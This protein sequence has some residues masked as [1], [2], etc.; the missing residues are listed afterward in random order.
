MTQSQGSKQGVEKILKSYDG[1]PE[2]E[3]DYPG[4][5]TSWDLLWNWKEVDPPRIFLV[6]AFS[7]WAYHE[8][9]RFLHDG[10]FP[11]WCYADGHWYE[12]E[13]YAREDP[14]ITKG[15]I[16]EEKGPRSNNQE[17]QTNSGQATVICDE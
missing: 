8:D 3:V 17:D 5:S 15:L 2:A 4:C 6:R 11:C 7:L 9:H 13:Q 16:Y 10:A 12:L 1:W 14:Y